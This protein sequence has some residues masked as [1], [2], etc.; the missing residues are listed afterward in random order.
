[1]PHTHQALDDAI[2][3]SALFCNILAENGAVPDS[4]SA[5]EIQ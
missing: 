5:Q 2:E 3:Q 4:L 1:M